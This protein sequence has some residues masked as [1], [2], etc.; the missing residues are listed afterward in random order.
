MMSG[1]TYS[2]SLSP[3]SLSGTASADA[4]GSQSSEYPQLKRLCDDFGLQVS[5]PTRDEQGARRRSFGLVEQHLKKER[6]LTPFFPSMSQLEA[7]V[8]DNL[9]DILHD[10]F[11]GEHQNA[12]V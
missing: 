10:Y 12:T 9:V 7:F 3:A 4:G 6:C 11:F 5:Q 2:T 1:S 8:T